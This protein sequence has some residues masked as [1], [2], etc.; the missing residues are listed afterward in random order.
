M[1]FLQVPV[2]GLVGATA[3]RKRMLSPEE[4][5]DRRNKRQAAAAKRKQLMEE[6]R[7]RK[8]AAEHEKKYVRRSLGCAAEGLSRLGGQRRLAG[9][10]RDSASK[11]QKASVTLVAPTGWRRR[12]M[13][14][15]D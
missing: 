4:L 15:R 14:F 12:R 9:A 3:K 2:P 13:L 11:A 10:L 8:E 1:S 5:E 6:K 7:R